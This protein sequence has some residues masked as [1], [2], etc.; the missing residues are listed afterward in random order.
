MPGQ[1]ALHNVP[2]ACGFGRE[3]DIP[4][5]DSLQRAAICSE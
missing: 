1:L 2:A 4:A 5:A 3:D